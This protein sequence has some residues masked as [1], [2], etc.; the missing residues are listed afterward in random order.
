MSIFRIS[1]ANTVQEWKCF[2]GMDRISSNLRMY[3]FY[4]GLA[5]TSS[6]VNFPLVEG[7]IVFSM[8]TVKME[9]ISLKESTFPVFLLIKYS[10]KK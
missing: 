5:L 1:V 9:I 3:V 10:Y 6:E 8:I 4:L 2:N 7:E